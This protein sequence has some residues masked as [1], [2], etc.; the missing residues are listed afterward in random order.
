[1]LIE[2]HFLVCVDDIFIFG[3]SFQ[4]MIKSLDLVLGRINQEERSIELRKSTFFAEVIDFP[5]HKKGQNG[6]QPMEKDILAIII[7]IKPRMA[8]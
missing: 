4:K 3:R 6:I 7:Y 1:V 2:K 5:C 8:K